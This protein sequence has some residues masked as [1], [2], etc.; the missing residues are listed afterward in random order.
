MD[1]TR[2]IEWFLSSADRIE[3]QII[4]GDARAAAFPEIAPAWAIERAKLVALRADPE[5]RGKV[6]AGLGE[7]WETVTKGHGEVGPSQAHHG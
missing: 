4:A 7:A 3:E 5:L 2:W 6:A 1:F